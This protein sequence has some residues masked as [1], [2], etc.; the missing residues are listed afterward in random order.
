MKGD[1]M[2]TIGFSPCPNDTFIFDALVNNKIDTEGIAFEV[3]MEDVETLNK[4]SFAA[5]LDITKL[6]FSS[7]AQVTKNYVLLD[8]G[9]A[10]GNGVG[11]ILISKNLIDPLA[12]IDDFT[13]AIPGFNTTAN[14]LLTMAYPKAQH[15]IEMVFSEIESAVLEGRADAGLIIHENRFTYQQKGL[16]K[17]IDLGEFWENLT[18]GPIPLGG[19]AIK[20]SL[21]VALQHKINRLVKKSVEYAFVHPESSKEYVQKHAQEMSETV[22]NQHIQL[23]VNEYSKNLGTAGRQA[24][25]LFLNKTIG[26][27]IVPSIDMPVFID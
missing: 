11:P 20:K 2:L 1:D 18:K 19:I 22:R 12:F 25:E 6:S 17:V 3:I 9:S 5:E 23:Y 15:K 27:G 26:T 4:R 8:A 24:I 7:F 10:L 14:F 16:H 21:P 13:I